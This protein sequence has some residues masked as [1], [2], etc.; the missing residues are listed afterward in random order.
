[1]NQ[2]FVLDITMSANGIYLDN[3]CHLAKL[4]HRKDY[5]FVVLTFV[6]IPTWHWKKKGN[7]GISSSVTFQLKYSNYLFNYLPSSHDRIETYQRIFFPSITH[8][9][10]GRGLGREKKD[11]IIPPEKKPSERERE[12]KHQLILTDIGNRDI[13][14]CELYLSVIVLRSKVVFPRSSWLSNEHL[15][16]YWYLSCACPDKLWVFSVV[17]HVPRP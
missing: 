1:M 2:L 11:K 16:F 10:F 13:F 17:L 9:R 4:D 12:K 7:R 14:P 6:Y 15:G 8:V 3:D 5:V